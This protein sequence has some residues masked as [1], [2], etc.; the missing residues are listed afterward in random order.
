MCM[1]SLRYYSDSYDL[2]ARVLARY[3]T[4]EW[5]PTT[6]SPPRKKIARRSLEAI[7]ARYSQ[8]SQ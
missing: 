4:G 2:V 1:V 8:A 3:R 7:G 6:Q 5:K